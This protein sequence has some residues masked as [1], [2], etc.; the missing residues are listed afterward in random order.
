MEFFFVS[1][2]LPQEAPMRTELFASVIWSRVQA[3][4]SVA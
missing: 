1:R 3:G 4:H 2:A